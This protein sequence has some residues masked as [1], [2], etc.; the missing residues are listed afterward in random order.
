VWN[1][2]QANQGCVSSTFEYRGI[3]TGRVLV[4]PDESQGDYSL[5]V[6]EAGDLLPD[7]S[8]YLRVEQAANGGISLHIDDRD[9]LLAGLGT[10]ELE[11]WVSGA[12]LQVFRPF[13]PQMSVFL[14]ATSL[15]G[16]ESGSNY[17]VRVRPRRNGLPLA[18]FSAGQLFQYQAG[19]AHPPAV[20]STY[21][22]A[23]FNPGHDGEGFIVEVLEDQRALV[24]W[25]T[26]DDRGN[27]RWMLGTGTVEANRI[28]IAELM[29]A[30]GG[31]FGSDFDPADVE[32]K[33]VGSL[34]ISFQDCGKAIANFSIDNI[35]GHQELSRLTDLQG[36]DCATGASPSPQDL[37]GSWYDPSH[38][39]EGFI[40]QQLS[41]SQALVM[42]FTYDA[43]GKA[44]WL[45]SNGTV[46]GNRISFPELIQPKG[47]K[48]GRSFD[49]R[50]VS[51]SPWGELNLELD[52]EGGTASYTSTAPGYMG[53][54]QQLEPLTRL[55]NSGCL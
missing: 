11:F 2:Y 18:G 31:R 12:G 40:V 53:G 39:G 51:R 26:Y 50:A 10:D 9:G 37:N 33:T 15:P 13:K 6:N 25:F 46:N 28:E 34:N 45:L 27:Q 30:S 47:G 36:H 32:L 24:Y 35:G 5:A 43:N 55:Q 29:D 38:D 4:L 17:Q 48:F 20:D 49:P 21:S 44:S 41:P 54:S 22:G 42:W 23:W 7:L 8:V 16:L 3:E 52:C 1:S 14:G 19:P